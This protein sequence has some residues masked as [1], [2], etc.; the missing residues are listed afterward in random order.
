MPLASCLARPGLPII[1]TV[2]FLAKNHVHVRPTSCSEKPM[3]PFPLFF[4]G[5]KV[6]DMLIFVF[7]HSY[8]LVFVVHH[9][10]V[11]NSLYCEINFKGSI[12]G[13]IDGEVKNP[14]LPLI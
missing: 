8:V 1:F 13:K 2:F 14:L 9:D 10:G 11:N 7:F 6:C 5:T 4:R 3:F 12:L